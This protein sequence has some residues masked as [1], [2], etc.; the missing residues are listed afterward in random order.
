M[1]PNQNSKTFEV[2]LISPSDIST[3][4][5]SDLADS[6]ERNQTVNILN[7]LSETKVHFQVKKWEDA[8]A[9]SVSEAQRIVDDYIGKSDIFIAVF[10]GKVGTPY[11][12]KK[13]ASVHEIENAILQSLKRKY[14]NK[15][16]KIMLF[17]SNEPVNAHE[18]STEQLAELIA[19]KKL[20]QEYQNRDIG[21]IKTYTSKEDLLEQVQDYLF[22]IAYEYCN[23][24]NADSEGNTAEIVCDSLIREG[25]FAY[26]EMDNGYS[27][28]LFKLFTNFR[29][30]RGVSMPYYTNLIFNYKR[31][32]S[33]LL[34]GLQWQFADFFANFIC[35]Y[36]S[37]H[38]IRIQREGVTA[39]D[40]RSDFF[41]YAYILNSDFRANEKMSVTLESIRGV[42]ERN[43]IKNIAEALKQE[44]FETPEKDCPH[45]LDKSSRRK[46]DF[47]KG[48]K[49]KAFVFIATMI[50][51]DFIHNVNST[52]LRFG[53]K[54]NDLPDIFIF[55]VFESPNRI[56]LKKHI[57]CY[58]DS[59]M[60][61][62]PLLDDFEGTDGKLHIHYLFER[63]LLRKDRMISLLYNEE[64]QK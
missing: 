60:I 15:A 57:R 17:F 11:G 23:G 6:I 39:K 26:L 43:F 44:I 52:L 42:E 45:L 5:R 35:S 58:D 25:V 4:T 2:A 1:N 48:D 33:P 16:I 12:G 7:T 47:N 62:K 56:E 3:K 8:P 21:L 29:Y 59:D 61:L 64:A 9:G 41:K 55:A 32:M 40:V 38:K 30:E 51:E 37:E 54:P 18:M 20:K 28:K 27:E 46:L 50:S 31:L 53:M 63:S 19:V 49:S 36:I 10:S 24:T 34:S 13:S 22:R 14:G